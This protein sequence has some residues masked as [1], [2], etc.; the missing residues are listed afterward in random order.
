MTQSIHWLFESQKSPEFGAY[1]Q[2]IEDCESQGKPKFSHR[3]C[4]ELGRLLVCR[5][6]APALHELCHLILIAQATG[7]NAPDRLER[8]FWDSGP[9]RAGNF[10]AHLQMQTQNG[11]RW[12]GFVLEPTSVRIDQADVQFRIHFSRMPLLSALM[13]FLVTALGYSAL[14]DTLADLK[15]GAATASQV[16]TTANQLAKQLYAF[17]KVHLPSAQQ[18]RKFHRLVDYLQT[19]CP[20]GFDYLVIQDPLV[21]DFWCRQGAAEPSDQ[22]DFRTFSGVFQAFVDLRSSLQRVETQAGLHNPHAL[23]QDRAAGEVDPD[24]L[25]QLLTASEEARNPLLEL[26]EPPANRIKYLNKLEQS[27][28]ECLAD[29]GEQAPALPLSVLRTEVFEPLRKQLTQALRDKRSTQARRR[30]IEEGGHQDYRAQRLAY[31]QCAQHLDQIL[32]AS[33]HVMASANEALAPENE[34]QQ[35]ACRQA[36]KRINRQGF[37]PS[38]MDAP[39]VQ[40]GHAAGNP[41]ILQLREQVEAFLAALDKELAD[42]RA[43]NTAFQQDQKI[44]AREFHKRYG[45]A[46]D[47]RNQETSA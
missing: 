27:A 38:E 23:G 41:W 44:F 30:L 4:Q 14:D 28:L 25:E 45:A 10:R 12:Q 37:K 39:E 15:A 20:Q 16:S 34:D 17:L 8:F 11:W 24:T 13:E 18:Q 22:G 2:L 3:T 19:E 47:D 29:T 7:S 5:T 42:D 9:A 31:S 35:A 6:Y 32:L 46:T 33:L 40:E 26:R 1:L 36:Y 21:L 43:L